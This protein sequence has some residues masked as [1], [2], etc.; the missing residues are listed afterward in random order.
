MTAK[1]A[2]ANDRILASVEEAGV[3]GDGST[4]FR[5]AGDTA[6]SIANRASRSGEQHQRQSRHDDPIPEI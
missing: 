5:S 2:T 3:V 4:I 1:L 6:E